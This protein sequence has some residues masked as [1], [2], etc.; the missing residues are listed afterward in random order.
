MKVKF[1][2]RAL[3]YVSLYLIA[4]LGLSI[5]C[6]WLFQE[7]AEEVLSKGP[8]T[9]LDTGLA[10]A[11]YAQSTPFQVGFY[12]IVTWFGG[13]G[14]IAVGIAVALVLAIK[15]RWGYLFIWL[16]AVL[17]GGLLNDALK[18]LF[19]RPRPIF[20]NPIFLARGYSFPSGHAMTSIITYSVLAF[21]LWREAANAYVRIFIGF[22]MALLVVLIGISRMAL[23]VHYLSDILGGYLAGGIWLGVCIASISILHAA[24]PK[25]VEAV[26]END[27]D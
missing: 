12:R 24:E 20:V 26:N 7:L 13:V 2:Q 10:D 21:L 16:I 22:G 1:S 9:A 4:G 15:R 23:G 25:A 18:Q 14:G 6:L 3:Q 8:I 27:A 19:I 11:L 5:I 17:G